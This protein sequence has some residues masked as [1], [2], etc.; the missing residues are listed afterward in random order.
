[1]Y[2]TNQAA[3][4]REGLFKAIAAVQA[5]PVCYAP[6]WLYQQIGTTLQ[7]DFLKNGKFQKFAMTVNQFYSWIL[8]WR[9][10][11]GVFWENGKVIK[12]AWV[13]YHRNRSRIRGSRRTGDGVPAFHDCRGTIHDQQ[14]AETI[15]S[16]D[17][18]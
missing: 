3:G 10:G 14:A 15:P 5:Y 8:P 6:Q 9:Y 1:V 17:L 18:K 7:G 2:H 12:T 13:P 11:G 4:E 16:L